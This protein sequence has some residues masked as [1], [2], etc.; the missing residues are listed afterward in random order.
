[1]MA[2]PDE[3]AQDIGVVG[4][5]PAGRQVVQAVRGELSKTDAIVRSEW[6]WARPRLKVSRSL[7]LMCL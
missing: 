6:P 3:A 5:A 1:M 4:A 2:C 7:A